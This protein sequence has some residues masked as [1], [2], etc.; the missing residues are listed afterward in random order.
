MRFI[1][2]LFMLTAFMSA[3][4][5]QNI[6]GHVMTSTENGGME[7]L[8]G[9]NIQWMGTGIGTVSD[10]DGHFILEKTPETDVL[11]VSFIGYV[12][13]TIPVGDQTDLHIMLAQANVLD[14]VFIGGKQSASKI[15]TANTVNS[16]DFNKAELLKAACCNLSE[17]FETSMV[18]DAEYKD[19]ITGA[20]TIRMLGLDG[21]YSQIMTENIQVVRGLS[22]AYG[23]T[24][25]PG[26]WIESFQISKGPG[27]VVNG[28]EGITGSINTELKK[29]YASDEE[30]F[31]LNLYGSNSGRYE[32][33]VNYAQNLNAKLSTMLLMSTSQN[34]LKLDYNQDGFLDA[35]FTEN[36]LLMNRWNYFGKNYESQAGIKA[37]LSD[38]TGGQTTFNPNLPHTTANGYGVGIDIRRLEGYLKNGFIFA[39]PNTSVGLI[40]NGSLHEQNSFFGLNN[41]NANEQYFNANLIGQT[42]VFNTNHLLKAGGSFTMNNVDE[43][44]QDTALVRKESVPGIFAEYTYKDAEKFSVLGGIRADF[45]NLYGTFVSPRLHA[46]YT[47]NTNTTFRLSA[48]KAYRVANVLAEN[49]SI[50]TSSRQF[51]IEEDLLPEEAWNFGATL[52]QTFYIQNKSLTLTLDAYHTNFIN[53]VIVDVDR[54]PHAIYVGNLHGTSYSNILQAEAYYEVFKNFNLRLAYRYSDVQ[55]TYQEGVL[56][57]PYVFK[58]RALVNINYFLEK[59]KWEFDATMQFYG[60]ARLPDMSANPEAAFLEPYTPE[61][62]LVLTQITKKFKLIDVYIGTENLT[63]YTQNNPI[64]GYDDPF[65]TNFDA[66][67]VYAPTMERKFYA[68]LRLTLKEKPSVNK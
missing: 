41:Y 17:S 42:Y 54:D 58:N 3:A 6:H 29:S 51:I 25:I 15:N 24:Y 46:K 62:V 5:S 32:A 26:S 45:H 65:S 68:G 21:V 2:I 63:N 36:Y 49:T 19:A 48:G 11:I 47:L 7:S 31:F 22:S 38:V 33:N 4:K 30:K 28:Y 10:I 34:H 53:Q 16:I 43:T 66:S 60:A 40:L 20:R 61:H 13:D 27:S 35:P 9:A 12:T 1:F 39:R 59:G 57:V 18:V 52:V 67:V 55:S 14:E 23:L 37:V 50:L 8:P 64:I 56:E 44:Y